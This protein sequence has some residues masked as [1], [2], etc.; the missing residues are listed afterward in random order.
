MLLWHKPSVSLISILPVS[1]T[2]SSECSLADSSS[3]V[4]SSDDDPFLPILVVHGD[5]RINYSDAKLIIREYQSTRNKYILLIACN[6]YTCSLKLSIV[7]GNFSALYH[8]GPNLRRKAGSSSSSSLHGKEEVS[9]VKG[10]KGQTSNTAQ[11]ST[12][13]KDSLG[14][15]SKVSGGALLKE[16]DMSWGGYIDN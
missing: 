15:I 8:P 3:S 7:F 2:S 4:S 12:N 11:S 13:L 9:N 1:E 5:F 16:T 10:R 6:M 14:E